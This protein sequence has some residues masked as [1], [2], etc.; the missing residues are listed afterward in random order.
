MSVSRLVISLLIGGLGSCIA[1]T[2]HDALIRSHLSVTSAGQVQRAGNHKEANPQQPAD[3]AWSYPKCNTW[4]AANCKGDH[5]PSHFAAQTTCKPTCTKE[6]CCTKLV[7]LGS[8]KCKGAEQLDWV[9]EVPNL[10][11]CKT[12]M[13]TAGIT[14][15][16]Y[17]ANTKRCW[18]HNAVI[19]NA[20][21]TTAAAC[22]DC[23]NCKMEQK[24]LTGNWRF[25]R[26]QWASCP[27]HMSCPIP[28][29]GNGVSGVEAVCGK[30]YDLEGGTAS[31]YTYCKNWQAGTGTPATTEV[32]VSAGLAG[33]A[34]CK[35]HCDA[36]DACTHF[37][38]YGVKCEG[39]CSTSWNTRCFIIRDCGTQ[40]VNDAGNYGAVYCKKVWHSSR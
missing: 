19:V 11:A 29:G 18:N 17:A 36:D 3:P 34:Q 31:Q 26:F 21:C 2:G 35:S 38:K 32:A 1:V 33:V 12:M 10:E 20:G 22:C 25:Y 16:A 13:H 37:G 27:P 15:F 5:M 14:F 40:S 7:D 24:T 39:T 9:P 23:D 4:A 8:G 30:G 28:G 6:I